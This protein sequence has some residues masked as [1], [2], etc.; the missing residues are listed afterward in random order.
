MRAPRRRRR[1]ARR[2]ALRSGAHS[3]GGRVTSATTQLAAARAAPLERV[4][5][6][7]ARAA[8]VRRRPVDHDH[9][10]PRASRAAD[11]GFQRS[12]E[13]NG[14]TTNSCRSGRGHGSRSSIPPS[15]RA[16]RRRG[17]RC[18]ARPGR[19]PRPTAARS[20]TPR[21][22]AR[23]GR[24]RSVSVPGS[25]QDGGSST[26]RNGTSM[27]HTTQGGAPRAALE[28]VFGGRELHRRRGPAGQGAQQRH[29][30]RGLAGAAARAGDRDEAHPGI[31]IQRC[32]APLRA[33]R[34]SR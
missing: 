12:G 1:P 2:G 33:R 8:L 16:P 13:R 5:D 24:S 29:R 31:L 32:V 26:I 30:D 6:L 4:E 7:G 10:R 17:V 15:P 21:A 19:R 22:R 11:V 14:W 20:P 34:G 23:R 18:T 25:P 3:R 9:G 27:S 28:H